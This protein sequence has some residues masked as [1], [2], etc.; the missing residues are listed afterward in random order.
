MDQLLYSVQTGKTG[1]EK[2]LGSLRSH[3]R[4]QETP[5][6]V[7]IIEKRALNALASSDKKVA[8]PPFGFLTFTQCAEVQN[9]NVRFTPKSGHRSFSGLPSQAF[10]TKTQD[11]LAG[12]VVP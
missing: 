3:S 1:F 6:A 10:G 8:A 2:A 4:S 5:H 9:I 12:L 7:R 11:F